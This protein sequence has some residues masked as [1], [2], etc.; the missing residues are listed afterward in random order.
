M[1]S[2]LVAMVLLGVG[3]VALSTSSAFLTSLQTDASLRSAAAVVAVAYM[4]EVKRRPPRSLTSEATASVDES[5]GANDLGPFRRTLIVE[6]DPAAPDLVRATVE[7]AY[8]GGMRGQG[9]VR[10]VTIIYRGND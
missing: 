8:P 6:Q 9:N 5:G 2:V 1:V 3:V 4:E 10:L 7:I